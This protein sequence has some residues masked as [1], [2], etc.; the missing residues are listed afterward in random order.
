[1]QFNSGSRANFLRT[2]PFNR[3]R[4]NSHLHAGHQHGE[5]DG[6]G[7]GGFARI[8]ISDLTIANNLYANLAGIIS[9]ATQTFN[10][11]SATSGFVPGATNLRELTWDTFAGYVQDNWKVR[12]GLTLNLGVRYEYWTPLDEKN[13]L[14][15]APVLKNNDL[16]ATLL[17]PNA[18]LDFIGKSVGRPFYKVDRNN[19]APNIGIAWDPFGKGT[20]SIRGGYR[21]AYVNDN[22]VTTVRNNVTTSR[23]PIREHA[24]EPG[25]P[26]HQSPHGSVAGL[27]SAPHPGRQL[28]H[29]QGQRH[30]PAGSEPGDP[31]RSGVDFRRGA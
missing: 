18:V 28:R 3:R 16:K 6:A 31:V 13:S 24:D 25:G 23:P 17:D 22:T 2:T 1:M 21:I 7:H 10:V 26:P 30:R 11:T 27:Q 9:S 5:H 19:F 29:H 14:F 20:T 4:H 15:L 12:P 8:G